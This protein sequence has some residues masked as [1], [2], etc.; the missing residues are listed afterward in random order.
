MQI[1]KEF[2]K[3]LTADWL[4]RILFRS[5]LMPLAAAIKHSANWTWFTF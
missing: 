1:N 3:T 4:W 2:T 5:W